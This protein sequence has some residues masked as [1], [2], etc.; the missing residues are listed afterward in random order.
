MAGRGKKAY[1]VPRKMVDGVSLYACGDCDAAFETRW[2]LNIHKADAHTEKQIFQCDMC[3]N[4]FKW[5]NGLDS[6]YDV[7]HGN[8]AFPCPICLMKFQTQKV[9]DYHTN[10]IHGEKENRN[11]VLETA[12]TDYFEMNK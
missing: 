6:H 1:R 10:A 2:N 4:K 9:L 7:K 11:F 8:H 5:Q 3:P 12:K